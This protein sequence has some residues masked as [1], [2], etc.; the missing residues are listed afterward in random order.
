[1]RPEAREHR[2][3]KAVKS[4]ADQERAMVPVSLETA[5]IEVTVPG[6]AMSCMSPGEAEQAAAGHRIGDGL[7][8]R[9]VENQAAAGNDLASGGGNIAGD[10]LV[11]RAK[12]CWACRTA[13]G[14][15]HSARRRL[16]KLCPWRR[17][18]GST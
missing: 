12:A 8:D 7:R 3:D 6:W 1:M 10:V 18:R 9:I 15:S 14:A 17:P 4:G 2:A 5:T 16:I 13:Q 11:G